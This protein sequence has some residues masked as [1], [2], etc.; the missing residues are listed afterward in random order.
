MTTFKTIF[1]T[2]EQYLEFRATWK[3]IASDKE[4]RLQLTSTHY[5]VYT[6]LRDK[7]LNKAFTPITNKVKL[8]NGT[9]PY[10]GLDTALRVM[11]NI[12]RNAKQ[13]QEGP[14]IPGTEWKIAQ[15]DRFLAPLE[16]K[17]TAEMLSVLSEYQHTYHR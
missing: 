7:D 17:L 4:L 12:I 11:H 14:I 13:Y 6:L 16:G 10:A 3:K 1:E 8:D 2:K 5:A 9:T 15:L